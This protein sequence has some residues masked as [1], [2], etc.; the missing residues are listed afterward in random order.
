MKRN[1]ISLSKCRRIFQKLK[2][3]ENAMDKQFV[4]QKNGFSIV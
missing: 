2:F 3:S 4:F 1:G